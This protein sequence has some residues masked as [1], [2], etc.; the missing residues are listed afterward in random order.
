MH[1]VEKNILLEIKEKIDSNRLVLPSL[2]EN[3]LAVRQLSSK[4]STDAN[5]LARLISRD[6]AMSARLIK[7]ANSALHRGITSTDSIK[8]AITRLG[9]PLVRQLVMQLAVLQ[10]MYG[11]SDKKYMADFV[12]S[13]MGI[14]TI[15]A[16][17]AAGYSHLDPDQAMLAGLIHDIGKLPLIEITS[18]KQELIENRDWRTR[19]ILRFHCLVG[20]LLLKKW[21]FDEEMIL[22]GQKHEDLKRDI[23]GPVDY[24]DLIIT[25]N[26]RYHTHE[27][28]PRYRH[29][30]PEDVPAYQKVMKNGLNNQDELR[31]QREEI[32]QALV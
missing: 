13:S 4:V 30:Q 31:V 21:G 3:A 19:T 14:G 27:K 7:V 20:G 25:A 12:D 22:V 11:C 2:P 32:I 24:V 8:A 10:V 1:Q 9:I 18:K 23:D 5:Q 6:T 17:L 15:S 28:S 26:L 29:I 16:T